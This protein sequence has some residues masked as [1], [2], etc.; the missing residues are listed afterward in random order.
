MIFLILSLQLSYKNK[1]YTLKTINTESA[2]Y[3]CFT[4]LISEIGIPYLYDKVK[5]SY[6]F[7]RDK[8]LTIISDNP[9]VKIDDKFIQLFFSPF[10]LESNI[11]V[12]KNEFI[13]VFSLL[14]DSKFKI[15]N[16]IISEEKEYNIKNFKLGV[17]QDETSIIFEI[18]PTIEVL[19]KGKD[20]LWTVTFFE[21]NYDPSIF[22]VN[23][24]GFVNKIERISKEGI[25]EFK[26]RIQENKDVN[27]KKTVNELKISIR[28]YK[29]R[30]IKNIVIDP[31]H[32]GHD[33]GGIGNGLYEKDVVLNLAK[34]VRDE[35][36]KMG[37]SITL[38]RTEDVFLSLKE[39]TQIADNMRANLFISIHCNAVG[40]KKKIAM[41]G[42]EVYFLSVAKTDWARAVE[43]TENSSIQFENG[44]I[45]EKGLKYVLWDLAQNQF[46][47]E[48]QQLAI[49][50]Q[51]SIVNECKTT[52]RGV[53][54]ANFYVL[55]LNYMPAVL[56]ETLF[57]TNPDDAK[58]LKDNN[59][60]DKMAK[61]IANGIKKYVDRYESKK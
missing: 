2:E 56:I 18:S 34:K 10:E 46:L 23:S 9:F 17:S 61:S 53:Q 12:E 24:G 30:E 43:A 44:G 14:V 51:E 36:K 19:Y 6:T 11:Y 22:N 39:R 21:P 41:S 52:D 13:N 57:I 35:L 28:N 27:I 55:R 48:S 50:I 45:E 7:Q 49:D 33:L 29:K 20:T 4:S 59:F 25:L 3:V 38:T 1:I 47:E 26:I 40:N 54:Q 37:F 58:K 31:G 5:K 16:D 42:T 32:G 15:Q 60:L 8:S